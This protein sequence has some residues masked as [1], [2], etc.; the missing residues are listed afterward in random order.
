MITVEEIKG[1]LRGAKQFRDL[2]ASVRLQALDGILKR[3]YALKG[4]VVEAS[5]Q[6]EV[7]V[8]AE[9]LERKISQR[10]PFLTLGE[11]MLALE[12]GVCGDYPGETRLAIANYI[13]W[14]G[15]YVASPERRT[16]LEEAMAEKRRETRPEHILPAA[17]RE[18]LNARA[19]REGALKAFR[20]FKESGDMGITLDGRAAS[21]YDYLSDLGKIKVTP[22]TWAEAQRRA[23][24]SAGRKTFAS[25]VSS[26]PAG[27]DWSAKRYLLG[28]YFESLVN[29]GVDLQL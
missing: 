6:S 29:R 3:A 4:Y 23:S 26:G 22:E 11:V 9:E 16:A 5:T 27:A 13:R 10:W 12:A 21:I 7:T 14:L 19:N 28:R 8:S 17:T 1:A 20:S 2:E 24:V 15:A 18:T 25:L